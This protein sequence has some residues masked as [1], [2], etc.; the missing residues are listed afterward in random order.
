[1]KQVF[2][3]TQGKCYTD[4]H[5]IAGVF[6]LKRI[7]VK[8]LKEIGYKYIGDQ[9]LYLNNETSYWYKLQKQDINP[10]TL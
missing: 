2:I 10:T 5:W 3:L 6:T 9:D 4:T 1:M 8:I 7:G